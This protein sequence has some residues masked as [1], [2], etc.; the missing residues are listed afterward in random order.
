MIANLNEM[1]NRAMNFTERV[2]TRWSDRLAGSESCL[3]CGDYLLECF[4]DFCDSTHIH[5]FD[6]HPGSFLGYLRINVVLYF[7][8]LLLLWLQ[9]IPLAFFF[10]AF[11]AIIAIAQFF[12]YKE[13]IDFLFPKKRGKNV[14]GHIE[15]LGEVKQQVI[16]SAHHDSAH[17]FNFLVDKPEKFA[18]K[19]KLSAI[20]MFG[21]G[22]GSG[23]LLVAQLLGFSVLILGYIVSGLFTILAFWVGDMWF[24]YA[25]EGTPGAGDNMIC[26]ALAME[27][28]KYFSLQKKNGNGL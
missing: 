20:G 19:T 14:V 18:I 8:A 23:L 27:V 17:I 4:S 6:V 24:F 22:I 10:S 2:T 3:S 9:L 15:P 12:Y 13:F 11:I 28:G 1:T 26:T 16:I 25:K 7:I 5:E 21:I